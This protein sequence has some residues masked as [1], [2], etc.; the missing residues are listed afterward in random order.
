V[1][2]PPRWLQ[3]F[4]AK[5]DAS[6]TPLDRRREDIARLPESS[7]G[8]RSSTLG[9]KN[10][11]VQQKI[12]RLI[13]AGLKKKP[14]EE[15]ARALLELLPGSTVGPALEALGSGKPGVGLAMAAMGVLDVLPGGSTEAKALKG[16]LEAAPDAARLAKGMM[17]NTPMPRVAAVDAAK[18]GHMAKV[19][20]SLPVHDP[21]AANA[22]RAL[23][24]EIDQQMKQIVD[25]GYKIEYVDK[26]PYKS[27]AEMVKDVRENKTLKVFKTGEGSD[28]PFMTREQNDRF[29]A[30]HDF[31]AHAGGGNQFGPVGEENAFRV[32]A[33]T[34]SPEAQ[35]A[36]AT[37]TRGQNSW[38]NFGPNAHLPVK[39]RPFATQKAALWPRELLGDYGDMLLGPEAKSE[40]KFMMPDGSEFTTRGGQA[41]NELHAD[42][43][44]EGTSKKKGKESIKEAAIRMPDGRIFTG[45]DHFSA[46]EKATA[47]GVPN[48]ALGSAA[49]GFTTSGGRFVDR[50]EAYLIH[51][52]KQV[53]PHEW[54]PELLA[55]ELNR[56]KKRKGFDADSV[57]GVVT[58]GEKRRRTTEARV[59]A[60]VAPSI[61]SGDPTKTW[62]TLFDYKSLGKDVVP[63]EQ[64]AVA[65]RPVPSSVTGM[66]GYTKAAEKAATTLRSPENMRRLSE[67]LQVGGEKWYYLDPLQRSFMDLLGE[68]EGKRRFQLLTKTI[69]ATS[70]N[71]EIGRNIRAAGALFPHVLEGLPFE[72]V[73][74]LN[75]VLAPGLGNTAHN[76]QRDLLGR[77]VGGAESIA[78]SPLKA[79]SFAQNL[80][81]NFEPA[82]IDRHFFRQA[83]TPKG[84]PG[85][86]GTEDA[87]SDL[88]AELAASGTLPVAEGRAATAPYQAALWIGDA[89]QGRVRSAPRPALSVFED[90]I[91]KAAVSGSMT[92]S[93]ALT[94]FMQGQLW[95]FA[96]GAPGL[97]RF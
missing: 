74:N 16:M 26:D 71:S 6:R 17:R 48:D 80:M 79:D 97:M 73:K 35:Q 15:Q 14:V 94:K 82:T 34:L 96:G 43:L 40:I 46:I 63:V 39:E 10:E 27:S 25:A 75:S 7:I 5:S 56:G 12:A 22:Y 84:P 58:R 52:G 18:A 91:R 49:D 85:Y 11:S 41:P 64:K 57:A 51:S 21:N 19:Y 32:H 61:I 77:V 38:V 13:K 54:P 89:L 87:A 86:L 36:L 44:A 67:G 24:K 45:R 31:V 4:V 92:P 90:E 72:K 30:V 9:I 68:D 55:E 20:E 3:D 2:K 29:R 78:K 23:N 93:Q 28:H 76:V 47:A 50:E 1:P 59:R 88:A 81:G 33:A 69:A 62:G 70:P 53:R 65:G 60:E 95:G 66:Q 42:M 83:G 8:P 37:E